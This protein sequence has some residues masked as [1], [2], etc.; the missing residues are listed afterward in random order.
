MNQ[1]LFTSIY[2]KLR[3]CGVWNSKFNLNLTG[4]PDS[5]KDIFGYLFGFLE[6]PQV[7]YMSGELGCRK[8]TIAFFAEIAILC[9]GLWWSPLKGDFEASSQS[10]AQNPV[11]LSPTNPALLKTHWV[12][13]CST[14][15]ARCSSGMHMCHTTR[16]GSRREWWWTWRIGFP[17]NTINY[18]RF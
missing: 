11:T 15:P 16:I 2:P 9:S 17:C 6:D 1:T 14:V 8:Q 10:L 7:M 18:I 12:P 5:W 4:Y 13:R 3:I